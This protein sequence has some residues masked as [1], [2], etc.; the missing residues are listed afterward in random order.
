MVHY[1]FATEEQRDLA[2]TARLILEKELAPRLEELEKANHG[3]GEYPMDVHEKMAEAGFYGMNIPE[4]WGGLGFDPVTQAIITE[5]MAQVDAGFTF[6]FYNYGTYF[7]MILKTGMSKE[8]KLSW[9]ERIISGE[10]MGTFCFTESS[11]GSDPA[12]MRTTAVQDGNDWV[13]NGTKCFASGAPKANYFLVA[14]WTDKTQRASRGVSFF[15]VEKERGVQIG[16]KENKLG[17]KLSE[18]SDAIFEDVRVPSNHMVGEVHLGFT[19]ALSLI[20]E[21]GRALGTSFNLGIAQAALDHAVSYAKTRRTFGK[22]IIDHQGIGFMI[23]D[24]QA[25]TEASRALMYEALCC[26]RDGIKTDY[27]NS[28][29][30]LYVTDHTMQTTLDAVQVL[31]G[32]GYMKDYP[33]EK[34]MRDAKIFQIFSG[35]NQIQRKNIAKAIA[36][37]D[38]ERMSK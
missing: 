6:A 30:K 20:S 7:P 37:K 35:T 9:A 22:R 24:M 18:T 27:L 3:L 28:V 33:V 15:L 26:Q 13:I 5:E 36:G 23:A 17:L 10:L 8:E 2:N 34:L 21:E 11:A 16:R 31:G 25:R 19:T 38:L 29:V 1:R 32:Y 12:A 14:A 4:E